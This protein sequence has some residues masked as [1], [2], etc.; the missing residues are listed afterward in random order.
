MIL[1]L[2][3]KAE[4]ARA[5]VIQFVTTTSEQIAIGMSGEGFEQL[6]GAILMV[7]DQNPGVREWRFAQR[8]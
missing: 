3:S 5:A 8:Q 7:L 6:A 2:S 1:F 4:V